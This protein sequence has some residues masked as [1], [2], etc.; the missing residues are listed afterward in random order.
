MIT[1]LLLALKLIL[2]MYSILSLLLMVKSQNV[3]ILYEC[4]PCLN[5]MKTHFVYYLI[6]GDI[7]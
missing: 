2:K 1:K 3:S 6:N 7:W 4:F 5:F